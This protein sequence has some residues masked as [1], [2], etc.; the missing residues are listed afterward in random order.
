MVVCTVLEIVVVNFA[1]TQL[2][3]VPTKETDQFVPD[4]N[5]NLLLAPMRPVVKH[6]KTQIS[7]LEL[8]FFNLIQ[9]V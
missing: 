7:K 4:S 1:S 8:D 6:F 2:D 5:L 3:L 9:I